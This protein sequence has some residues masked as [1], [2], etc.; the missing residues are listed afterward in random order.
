MRMGNDISYL[1]EELHNTAKQRLSE[2]SASFGKLAG[3]FSKLKNVKKELDKEDLNQVFEE[4][5]SGLCLMCEKCNIC[6]NQKFDESYDQSKELVKRAAEQGELTIKEVPREFSRRCIRTEDF[7]REIN[8]GVSIAKL[9]LAWNNRL[10][11]S[12]EAVAG[13][14]DEMA[15]IVDEFSDKLYDSGKVVDMKKRKVYSIMRSHRIRVKRLLL[16]ERENRGVQLHMRAKCMGGRCIT[17]KEAAI[18]LSIVLECRLVPREDARNV[19][20]KD[21]ADYVFCEDTNFQV[22]TGVARASKTRGELS[23][24]NFSFLYPESGDLIMMLSD[25]MGTG[26]EAYEESERVIELLEQFLEAGF[27]E[28]SA[29]KM[30]NSA[31]VLR[32]DQTIF[33]TMD[34]C[35]INLCTGTCELVKVGAA[36]TFIKRDGMVETV[37]ASTLPAGMLS[38]VDYEVKCKKLYDGDFVIMVSDGVLECAKQEDKDAY[39]KKVIEQLKNVSPQE[40]AN[41]IL[42]AGLELHEYQPVDDMTVLVCGIW[43]K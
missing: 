35:V 42:T 20:G 22:L 40:I 4:L 14:F 7:V 9:K 13:Q 17:T 30:I 8:R 27:R 18:L 28:E 37:S 11:E 26:R 15:R 6:W 19:I 1:T 34:L 21:Y 3:S 32:P 29:I 10:E 16:L 36:T 33:S 25:G 31:L 23:G 41:A 12:R 2:L 5:S 24:D 43:K 39:F 38:R